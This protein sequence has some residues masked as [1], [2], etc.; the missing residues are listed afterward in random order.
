MSEQ[1]RGDRLWA[2]LNEAHTLDPMQQVIL[3]EACRVADRLD[4]LDARIGAG[5]DAALTEARQQQNVM[6][7]LL[8]S[9]RLPDAK[10]QRPQQR[11]ARG[12]YAKGGGKV[13]S[14]ERARQQKS[15]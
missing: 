13:S 15:G 9:L 2:E 12:A 5:D 14:L 11:G 4:S 6:K 7:Q 10:G 8:V 1:T 3:Q